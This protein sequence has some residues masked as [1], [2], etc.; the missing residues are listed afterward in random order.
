[1]FHS[2][3]ELSHSSN[4]DF[5]RFTYLDTG[6]VHRDQLSRSPLRR[7]KRGY[8]AR[9]RKTPVSAVTKTHVPGLEMLRTA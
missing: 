8:I 2:M 7:R 6:V 3:T 5:E 4:N 1:M 9:R